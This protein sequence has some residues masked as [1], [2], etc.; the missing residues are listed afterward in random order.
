MRMLHVK[1][2]VD[3][4]NARYSLKKIYLCKKFG[5]VYI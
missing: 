3:V 2:R 5:K 1:K 4:A